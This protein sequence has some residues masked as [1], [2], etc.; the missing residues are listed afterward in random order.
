MPADAVNS[1]GRLDRLPIS[2]FHYR[3]LGLIGAGMFL[4]AFEIY[5]AGGVLAVLVKS[6]P[7]WPTMA[8]SSRR[9]SPA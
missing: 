1:G 4:D 3:V 2:A 9:R 6:G 5:L 8:G 7:I